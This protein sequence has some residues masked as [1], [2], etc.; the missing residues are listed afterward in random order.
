MLAPTAFLRRRI[1][2]PFLLMF[3]RHA[4]F[5]V[6]KARARLAAL[7]RWIQQAADELGDVRGGLGGLD[8]H[9]Q[10]GLKA[11]G[12]AI[13]LTEPGAR[14]NALQTCFPARDAAIGL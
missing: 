6:V 11:G 10:L 8:P 13:Q 1:D 2:D 4:K 7:E 12:S 3:L 9:S 14:R 5:D